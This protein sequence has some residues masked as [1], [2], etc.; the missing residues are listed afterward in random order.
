MG[1]PALGEPPTAIDEASTREGQL[2]DHLDILSVSLGGATGGLCRLGESPGTWVWPRPSHHGL[3]RRSR[4]SHRP[5]LMFPL[6]R[7]R[8][9]GGSSGDPSSAAGL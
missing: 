8:R 4:V 2:Q 3:V 6:R 9:L 7:M 5:S 1:T